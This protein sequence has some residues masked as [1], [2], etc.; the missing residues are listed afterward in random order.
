MP[1]AQGHKRERD[2]QQAVCDELTLRG[3]DHY[4]IPNGQMRKGQ[5]PE[6]GLYPG[7]PDLHIPV[8]HDTE[9]T[10]YI[11]LK[12][13]KPESGEKTY[14]RP[15]QQVWL[16]RLVALGHTCCVCRSAEMVARVVDHH[17]NEAG[18]VPDELRWPNKR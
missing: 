3:I 14:T 16:D 2:L 9:G 7:V 5:R 10:L 4:G 1:H 8:S 17:L 11:E 12:R 13:I 6:V 15:E 18:G